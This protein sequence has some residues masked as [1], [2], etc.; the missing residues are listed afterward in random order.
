MADEWTEPEET[1]QL[2]PPKVLVLEDQLAYRQL[3]VKELN[4]RGFRAKGEGDIEAFLRTAERLRPDLAVVDLMLNGKTEA[5]FALPKQLRKLV[6]GVVVVAHTESEHEA[7]VRRA[8][9]DT[10]SGS[11]F[12]GYITK[13]KNSIEE[14]LHYLKAALDGKRVV[15]HEV[16]EHL[17]TPHVELTP[18]EL[19]WLQGRRRGLKGREFATT[20]PRGRARGLLSDRQLGRIGDS[21]KRK[22]GVETTE[23]AIAEA[24]RLRVIE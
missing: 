17:V 16:T 6:P 7:D 5:S 13:N 15:D 19:R 3:F 11:A 10:G 23:E 12:N 4:E 22:L 20:M 21:V 9:V 18:H 8:M 1:Q 2:D 14:I 24:V